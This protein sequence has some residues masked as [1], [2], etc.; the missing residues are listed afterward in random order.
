MRIIK[1]LFSAFLILAATKSFSQQYEDVDNFEDGDLIANNWANWRVYCYTQNSDGIVLSFKNDNDGGNRSVHAQFSNGTTG[2]WT[3]SYISLKISG[4]SGLDMHKYTGIRFHVKGSAYP[5]ELRQETGLVTDYSYYRITAG[6]ISSS[7]QEFTVNFSA[8]HPPSWSGTSQTE[9]GLVT[10][11]SSLSH[12][13]SFDFNIMAPTGTIVDLWIDDVELIKNTSYHKTPPVTPTGLKQA[14]QSAGLELGFDIS[15]DYIADSVLRKIT[16][17]NAISITSEWGPVMSEIKRFPD[18]YD[19]SMADATIK[20]AYVNGLHV[21]GEHLIWHLSTPDWLVNGSYTATQVD[22]I[23][24]DFI[25][26][27]I[28]YFKTNYPGLITHWCVVNE[29]IDD[30]TKSYRNSFWYQ[31]LGKDYIEKAFTYAHEA[32][33]TIK[34]YYNDYGVEGLSQKSDSMYSIL[35]RL[36]AKGVPIDGAGLQMHVSLEEFPGKTQLLA[37]MSRLG[38]LGLEVYITEMDVAINE[39]K[40][41]VS[42]PK[43]PQQGEVFRD[44]L[45]ACLESP[46]CNDYTIWGITDRYSWYEQFFHKTDWPLITDTNFQPKDAWYDILDALQQVVKAKD[47][48]AKTH[49]SLE[50]FPNPVNT[51][52]NITLRFVENPGRDVKLTVYNLTGEL[53]YMQEMKECKKEIA[54]NCNFNEGMY[55]LKLQSEKINYSGILVVMGNDN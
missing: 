24:E 37:N 44:A 13:S 27:T 6:T 50:L 10:L 17:D 34:L 41:G 26:T 1:L 4:L 2:T 49:A 32:D 25:K 42:T 43:Y 19:F 53:I 15:P 54:F 20:W 45:E 3:N 48:S 14:A 38:A 30:N 29:A 8:L 28:I 9:L 23:M 39:D 55:I 11:D 36:I 51:G 7:W 40:S 16:L 21:K 22:S 46:Y 33:S 31:K 35:S 47:V 52:K 12:S 5:L 18:R